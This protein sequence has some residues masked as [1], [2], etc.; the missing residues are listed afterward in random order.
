[1]LARA[2][3]GLSEGTISSDVVHLEQVRAL[4][5]RPTADQVTRLFTG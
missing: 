2:A 1:M 4:R 5:I 3:A